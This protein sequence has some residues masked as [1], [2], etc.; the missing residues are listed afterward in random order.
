MSRLARPARVPN[1]MNCVFPVLSERRF[2]DIQ[3]WIESIAC[4]T[5]VDSSAEVDGQQYP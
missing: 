5:L 2:D 1:Q 3:A 4:K